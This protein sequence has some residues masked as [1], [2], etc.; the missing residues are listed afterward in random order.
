MRKKFQSEIL[1]TKQHRHVP[2]DSTSIFWMCVIAIKIYHPRP[3]LSTP[4]QRVHNTL[5]ASYH[6]CSNHLALR[7]A[8]K[9]FT[10]KRAHTTCIHTNNSRT[11]EH[12]SSVTMTGWLTLVLL[13]LWVCM[14]WKYSFIVFVSMKLNLTI[15]WYSKS[16]TRTK[17]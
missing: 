7:S 3:S 8:R 14:K 16:L 13:L 10:W 9:K 5:S 15:R 2:V 6:D 11:R 4:T 17:S 12:T 1:D